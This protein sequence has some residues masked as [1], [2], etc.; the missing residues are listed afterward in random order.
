MPDHHHDVH[1]DDQHDAEHATYRRLIALLD[2]A[3]VAYRLIDHEPD[4]TTETVSALR[5]HPVADAAKCLVLRAKTDRRT[6]RYVLAVVPGDR[7]VDLAAIRALFGARYVGF[8]DAATAQRLA[9]A[10]PGTV[11]PFSFDPD[12]EVVADPEVVAR[13]RLYFNAAR[14]DRSLVISGADYA[15]LARPRVVPIT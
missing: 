7:R 14:L 9:R 11:L 6:T 10:V 8:C 1:H 15:R 13:P 4:G 3:T 5:G 2:E 12:L